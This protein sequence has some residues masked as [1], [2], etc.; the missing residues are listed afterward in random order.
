MSKMRIW[1]ARDNDGSVTLWDGTKEMPCKTNGDYASD[2]HDCF[3]ECDSPIWRPS[4]IDIMTGSESL[5][6]SVLP[7]ECKLFEVSVDMK[8]VEEVK[9]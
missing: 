7:G 3:I 1:Y 6:A 9:K 8:E 5:R 4:I 2:T